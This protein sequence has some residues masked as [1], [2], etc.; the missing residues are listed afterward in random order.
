MKFKV[1]I[2]NGH[3]HDTAGKC[4]P[5]RRHREYKWAREIA[6]RIV[7]QLCGYG[8]DAMLITPEENDISLP[9]R[10]QRVN[11]WCNRFGKNNVLLVSIHNNAAGADGK[12][13]NA[14]GWCA[15]TSKGQTMGDKLASCI[16]KHA[17]VLLKDYEKT[18]TP[19]E[20]KAHQRA[21]R[22]DYTDSDPDLE[23]NFYILRKTLCPATLTENMFQDTKADVEWL[24][25]EH[26]KQLI[27]E[28]HVKGIIDYIKTY[29]AKA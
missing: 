17:E 1:L 7:N 16:Y 6:R 2:D 15:F 28:L 26:N 8:Y 29:A 10:A 19:A 4:S 25:Q 27:V 12:W 23:E 14:R 13:H 18:I 24:N 11:A 22:T 21:V 9:T 5:D 20:L 3:G